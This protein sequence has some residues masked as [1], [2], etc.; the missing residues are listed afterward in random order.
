MGG[1]RAETSD[2]PM[3]MKMKM[4]MLAMEI[5]DG[6]A[7]SG[8]RETVGGVAMHSADDDKA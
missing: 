1:A 7:E 6:Y 2:R 4:V 8:I 3:F 5:D